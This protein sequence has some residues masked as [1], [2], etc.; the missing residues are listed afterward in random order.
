[1]GSTPP[2]T[3]L[4]IGGPPNLPVAVPSVVQHVSTALFREVREKI[5]ADFS[6]KDYT[7]Q[8]ILGSN[9]WNGDTRLLF[10]IEIKA[11]VSSRCSPETSYYSSSSN[12]TTSKLYLIPRRGEVS[13]V[14][15]F[16]PFRENYPSS[17]PLQEQEPT[18]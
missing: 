14:K 15:V 11:L 10:G 1:M 8:G 6:V 9:Y 13:R 4:F 16:P 18:I 3:T 2:R 7:T 5:K 17:K 12:S